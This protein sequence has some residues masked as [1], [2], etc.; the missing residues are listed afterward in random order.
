MTMAD[1]Y[2]DA[3]RDEEN[4]RLR[5]VLALRAMSASG[6]SQREI[7]QALGITQPAVSQQ[8]A[9]APELRAIHPEVLV[10]VGAPVLK[11]LATERGF[12]RMAVFGSVARSEAGGDSD[13]DLLVES[14]AGTSSLEFVAFA[15]L[16]SEVLGRD[17]DLVDYASLNPRVDDDIRREAVLL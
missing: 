12:G 3:R 2:A 1:Q 5:R 17:V 9:A 11:A 13:I 16:L 15:R 6:M 10:A 4:A 7:A 14:P 8:L